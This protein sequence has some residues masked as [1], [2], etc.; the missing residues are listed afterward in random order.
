[1]NDEI[2][3]FK[4]TKMLEIGS[5]IGLLVESININ[6]IYAVDP[7][8]KYKIP[9]KFRHIRFFEMQSDKFFEQNIEKFD[10]IYIDGLHTY[11][12]SFKDLINSMDSLKNGGTSLIYLDDVLPNDEFSCLEDPFEA[13]EA[14][15]R[16]F[17]KLSDLSWMGSVYK[18][19]PLLIECEFLYSTINFDGKYVT[20]IKFDQKSNSNLEELKNKLF[21][22]REKLNLNNYLFKDINLDYY[23]IIKS[24]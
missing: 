24:N 13:F 14:R 22:A 21:R 5:D 11:D 8:K 20:R 4:L 7:V 23:N 1:M 3:K 18:L 10:L 19:I 6:R 17:G 16:H 9:F 15:K 2:N 12:Q